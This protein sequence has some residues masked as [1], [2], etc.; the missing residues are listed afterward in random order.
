MDK[1]HHDYWKTFYE[2]LAKN[3][4]CATFEPDFQNLQK[5]ECPDFKSDS[6]GLEIVTAA[7]DAQNILNSLFRKFS[8]KKIQDIPDGLLNAAG[9][10]R[11]KIYQDIDGKPVY[12]IQSE[13]N[14][15]LLFLKRPNNDMILAGHIGFVPSDELSSQ[16]I[17]QKINDKIEKLNNNY[18]LRC[19]NVVGVY[20]EQ[21]II[22]E[23]I[24]YQEEMAEM[25]REQ[26]KKELIGNLNVSREKMFN[27]LYVCFP[28]IVYQF[29]PSTGDFD[30]RIL[31]TTNVSAIYDKTRTEISN[32]WLV[33]KESESFCFH[34]YVLLILYVR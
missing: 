22:P 10:D 31:E 32:L 2:L 11:A 1:T 6:I 17:V 18:E 27:A 13:Q 14:G 20:I 9:F 7:T 25:M 28:D 16:M 4:I 30:Y 12:F 15:T 24:E 5:S 33:W 29:K 34:F 26:I 21:A 8:N 3:Y 19:S 23:G